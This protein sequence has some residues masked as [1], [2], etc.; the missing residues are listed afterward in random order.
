VLFSEE[1]SDLGEGVRFELI[2]KIKEN[3]KSLAI[4]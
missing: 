4:K 2:A 1:I 3:L